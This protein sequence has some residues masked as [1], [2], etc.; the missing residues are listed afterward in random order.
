M[1]A[2]ASLA[3]DLR[4]LLS[5]NALVTDAAALP[6][7]GHDFWTQRGVPGIVVRAAR[8][9]DVSATLRYAAARGIAVVPRAAGTNVS[10]GFLPTPARIL[11]DLR[12]MNR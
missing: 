5:P 4:P 2:T 1:I 12:P 10:A 11:L 3:N 9:D 6:A 8:A 7:Y